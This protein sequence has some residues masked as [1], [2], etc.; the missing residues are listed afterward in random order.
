MMDARGVHQLQPQIVGFRSLVVWCYLLVS[1]REVVAIDSGW[2]PHGSW[3]KRWFRQAGRPA[4]D[5]KAILLSHGHID[6][7]GCAAELQSWSGAAI[8][9]HPA[10][11]DLALGRHEGPWP[12]K[13]LQAIERG[14]NILWWV[15]RMAITHDLGEGD[16]L[17][18]C[19]G[20]DVIHLPGHTP[21]HVAFHSRQ[22]GV[23]FAADAILSRDRRVYFPH[24][25]F[26]VDDKLV[27][28]SVLRLAD[29]QADWVY[30][31]HHRGL[32]HNLLEDVRRYAQARRSMEK[33]ESSLDSPGSEG[34][35]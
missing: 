1:D 3:I 4:S 31:S 5:L 26:N 24:R 21:G 12:S 7:V 19:G 32:A 35:G 20:I 15:R 13:I 18:Y 17:P 14:S 30:P 11:K 28:R 34:Y 2:G 33:I 22:T 23:L 25:R 6:H 29:H 10:D 9:L 8:Y 27:R 16:V